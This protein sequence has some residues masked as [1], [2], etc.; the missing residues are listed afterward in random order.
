M[1]FWPPKKPTQS[2]LWNVLTSAAQYEWL[3]EES[4]VNTR[5]MDPFHRVSR[6]ETAAILRHCCLFERDVALS[7]SPRWNDAARTKPASLFLP[8]CFCLQ[9]LCPLFWFSLHLLLAVPSTTIS[10]SPPPLSDTFSN[11]IEADVLLKCSSK[12][13]RLPNGRVCVEAFVKCDTA[14]W[15]L[16]RT[17]GHFQPCL[18]QSKVIL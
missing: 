3:D 1:R 4:I 8:H 9:F 16:T 5:G 2:P 12:W 18:W 14:G 7:L 13:T 11:I 6:S 17:P 10:H 15:V